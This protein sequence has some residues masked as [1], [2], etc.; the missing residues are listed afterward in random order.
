MQDSKLRLNLTH[1]NQHLVFYKMIKEKVVGDARFK[2]T[3]ELDDTQT[4]TWSS[5]NL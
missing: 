1:P 3:T 2:L 5:I 4:N